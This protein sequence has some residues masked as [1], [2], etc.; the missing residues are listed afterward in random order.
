MVNNVIT[1]NVGAYARQQIIQRTK[2]DVWM[3]TVLWQ[4][5]SMVALRLI[6]KKTRGRI[7][8]AC[9]GS[10]GA[11]NY[12]IR[13]D[14]KVEAEGRLYEYSFNTGRLYCVSHTQVNA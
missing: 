2:E 9:Q 12:V 10:F 8:R 7:H 6:H 5:R 4:I 1:L 3:R 13:I 11:G 14:G